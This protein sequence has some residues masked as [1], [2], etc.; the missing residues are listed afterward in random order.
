VINSRRKWLVFAGILGILLVGTVTFLTV[1]R[2]ENHLRLERLYYEA[3]GVYPYFHDTD[4]SVK[5]V[6]EIGSYQEDKAEKML[7]ALA[8]RNSGFPGISV[9]VE[10]IHELQV[11]H[12]RHIPEFLAGLLKLETLIDIRRAAAK[13]LQSLPC[14]RVCVTELLQYLEQID[15]G[16]RN[17][18]DIVVDPYFDYGPNPKVKRDIEAMNQ[19]VRNAI[20]VE[21]KEIYVMLYTTLLNQPKTTNSVLT[22]IYGLGS[23]A[24]SDF[25]IDFA[26]QSDDKDACAALEESVKA[27]G[28][29]T[30]GTSDETRTRLEHA[31]EVLKCN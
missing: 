7:F 9:Q 2:I 18:E 19:K 14:D 30:K 26:V 8:A 27:I 23:T 16:S 11:R 31:I 5:A 21:Q 4:S 17:V 29:G 24:P 1:R 20:K 15:K 25:A 12:D 22:D 6:H 28:D 3:S 10:A 13:A